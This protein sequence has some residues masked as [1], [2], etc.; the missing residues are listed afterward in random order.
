[1]KFNLH[2]TARGGDSVGT[3]LVG[4]Q[5]L[6]PGRNMF[7]YRCIRN[8]LNNASLLVCTLLMCWENENVIKNYYTPY[9]IDSKWLINVKGKTI[10]LIQE[11]GEDFFVV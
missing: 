2:L 11:N 7:V 5:K 10:K 8:T 9:K 6:P 4:Q 3:N 1:M